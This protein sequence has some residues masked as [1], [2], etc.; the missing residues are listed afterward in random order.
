M[1]FIARHAIIAAALVLGPSAA[2]L[3][4]C[5]RIRRTWDSLA[6]PKATRGYFQVKAAIPSILE[7]EGIVVR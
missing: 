4:P 3:P 6:W 1:R 2:A 7:G 5:L